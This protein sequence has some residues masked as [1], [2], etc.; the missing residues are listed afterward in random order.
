MEYPVYFKLTSQVK[1]KVVYVEIDN[2]ENYEETMQDPDFEPCNPVLLKRKPR[3]EFTNINGVALEEFRY[4]FD[5]M[6]DEYRVPTYAINYINEMIAGNNGM[7]QAY[8]IPESQ[9]LDILGGDTVL[10]K[11]DKILMDNFI[12]KLDSFMPDGYDINW[13]VDTCKSPFFERYP[14]FGEP[15]TCVVL[16]VYPKNTKNLRDYCYSDRHEYYLEHNKYETCKKDE[17]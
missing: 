8:D 3:V 17:D 15:C 13:D 10:G 9:A 5:S 16:R 4:D 2:E 14:E 12:D 7:D 1:R 11:E 6:W